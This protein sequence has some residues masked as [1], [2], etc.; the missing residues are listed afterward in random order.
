ME[1]TAENSLGILV[2]SLGIAL[3]CSVGFHL[4][5]FICFKS[6]S[7]AVLLGGFLA[8]AVCILGISVNT[9]VLTCKLILAWIFQMLPSYILSSVNFLVR[10]LNYWFP[11]YGYASIGTRLT[12]NSIFAL[13]LF[14]RC[15][16][17]IFSWLIQSRLGQDRHRILRIL[18]FAC[19]LISFFLVAAAIQLEACF[20]SMLMVRMS[21]Y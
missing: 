10:G 2:D 21:S 11:N 7:C 14:F 15:I 16:A 17:L 4:M 1:T 13:F 20:P 6:Y 9:P 5:S 19:L 12:V 18:K 8:A 3:I